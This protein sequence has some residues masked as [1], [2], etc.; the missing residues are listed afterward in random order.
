MSS[1]PILTQERINYNTDKGRPIPVQE[2]V[3][4]RLPS[5]YSSHT[6]QCKTC[7]PVWLLWRREESVVPAMNRNPI[8]S[9]INLANILMPSF[10]KPRFNNYCIMSYITSVKL[11]HSMYIL[12]WLFFAPPPVITSNNCLRISQ[13]SFTIFAVSP[14]HWYFLPLLC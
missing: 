3:S 2:T 9:Q 4:F 6:K 14:A 8:Q 5:L 1:L 7:W 11:L 13:Y 12:S 10:F